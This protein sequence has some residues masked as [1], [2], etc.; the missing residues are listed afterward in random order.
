M[1]SSIYESQERC[2]SSFE[3]LIDILKNPARDYGDQIPP[4]GVANEFSRFK[5]W[6]GSLGARQN[7][8]RRISLDY[9]L[10]DSTYYR[11]RVVEFLDDLHASLQ[12]GEPLNAFLPK[13]F[14]SQAGCTLE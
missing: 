2:R 13:A 5:V 3:G 10:R 9:R 11:D 14:V 6:A 8:Q 4:K 7:P 1:V 12:K